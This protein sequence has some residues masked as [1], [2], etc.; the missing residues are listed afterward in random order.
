LKLV[1]FGLLTAELRVL[2][3]QQVLQVPHLLSERLNHGSSREQDAREREDRMRRKKNKAGERRRQEW[4][5]RIEERRS[6]D[7]IDNQK[8]GITRTVKKRIE[9]KE[10]WS[11]EKRRGSKEKIFQNKD[12]KKRDEEKHKRKLLSQDIQYKEDTGKRTG[13]QANR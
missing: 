12:G 2:P 9:L 10:K 3:P 6:R 8:K 4:E 7:R 1:D 11:D 5:D 13:Q